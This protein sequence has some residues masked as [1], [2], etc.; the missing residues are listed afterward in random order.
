MSIWN[1]KGINFDTKLER[2]TFIRGYEMGRQ[3]EKNSKKKWTLDD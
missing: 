1:F 2:D 3:V